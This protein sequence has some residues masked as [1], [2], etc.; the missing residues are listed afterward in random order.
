[1]TVSDKFKFTVV[2][3]PMVAVTNIAGVAT[4]QLT[5]F[6]GCGNM[7]FTAT[8]DGV[9]LGP[10]NSLYCANMDKNPIPDGSVNSVDLSIFTGDYGKSDRPC[11]DFNCQG[12]V[13]SVDLSIFTGHYGH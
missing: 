5:R 9:V 7:R 12:G 3:T 6:G 10:S 1:V 13:N 11:S 8:S 4:A 2:D